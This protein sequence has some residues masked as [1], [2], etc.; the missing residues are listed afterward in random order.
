MVYGATGSSKN[1]N[2]FNRYFMNKLLFCL[3]VLCC[4]LCARAQGTF[5]NLNFGLNQV[6]T[7]TQPGSSLPTTQALP[8]WSG[9]IGGVPQSSVLY[10]N[11]N[12]PLIPAISLVS[13]D[14]P[15]GQIFPGEYEAFLSAG[16]GPASS[17]AQ[18]GQFPA[19]A[20]TIQFVAL[21]RPQFWE[22]TINGV[23]IPVYEQ[24]QAYL[25]WRLYQ[26]DISAFAGQ[27]GELA[28]SALNVNGSVG[29][30]SLTDIQFVSVPEP[31]SLSLILVGSLIGWWRCKPGQSERV[32]AK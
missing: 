31:L 26:G 17:I 27:T 14:S 32:K 18:T 9:V 25:G 6:P 4:S 11:T 1:S 30:M 19:S 21:G 28:F 10:N 22:L 24:S 12:G 16:S 5:R 20:S 7:S 13:P 23:N 8:F 2:R 15:V 3:L 29:T